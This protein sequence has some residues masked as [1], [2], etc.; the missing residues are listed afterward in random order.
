M[1]LV[2]LF[3]CYLVEVMEELYEGICMVCSVYNVDFVGGD[4]IFLFKGLVI[5]VIVIGKG[6]KECLI[7]CNIVKV[8]DLICIIGNL[9]AVYM[10]L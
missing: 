4:I 9:G 7:Y 10:G 3:N 6:Y 8:G 1:V 2:V 5:S